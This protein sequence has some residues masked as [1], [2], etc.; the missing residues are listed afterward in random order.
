MYHFPG[1]RF[2]LSDDEIR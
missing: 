1:T 2:M